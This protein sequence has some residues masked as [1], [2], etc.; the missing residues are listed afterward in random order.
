MD[1]DNPNIIKTPRFWFN[2]GL[3]VLT[4]LQEIG[5]LGEH[6]PGIVTAVT[7]VAGNLGL[8]ALKRSSLV[9]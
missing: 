1:F 6:G 3:L 8:S 2:I 7:G 9:R 4:I 5:L